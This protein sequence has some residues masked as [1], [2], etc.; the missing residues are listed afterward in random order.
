MKKDP[1]PKSKDVAQN[2]PCT[3]YAYQKTKQFQGI[4]ILRNFVTCRR[5][6]NLI[7]EVPSTK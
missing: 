3:A 5:V 6:L 7:V 4:T 2:R 1:S